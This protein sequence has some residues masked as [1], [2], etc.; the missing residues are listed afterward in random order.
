MRPNGGPN[1][2]FRYNG[3]P[4]RDSVC[5]AFADDAALRGQMEDYV[6]N[7]WSQCPHTGK[8][9]HTQYHFVDL[10]VQRSRYEEGPVGTHL[11]NLVHG[12]NTAATTLAK[13]ACRGPSPSTALVPNATHFRPNQPGFRF[14]CAQALMML[15]HF[16]GDLHQPMHVGGV[17]LDGEGRVVDPDS[18]AAERARERQTSTHGANSL[19]FTEDPGLRRAARPLG[20]N[21]PP[22][23]QRRGASERIRHAGDTTDLGR[24]LGDREPRSRGPSA[25]AAAL[26]HSA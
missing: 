12:I 16:V 19:H 17:Y 25:E 14:T 10:A 7:N 3:N 4:R 5:R 26:L 8:G 1:R 22:E 24:E 21:Q 11:W 23:L 6:R 18:S 20:R 9:C 15:V 13:P 2:N